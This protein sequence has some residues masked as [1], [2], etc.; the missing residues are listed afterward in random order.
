MPA[1]QHGDAADVPEHSSSSA[2]RPDVHTT[3]EPHEIAIQ[4]APSVVAEDRSR[5][6]L[7]KH[8]NFWH[9]DE[10]KMAHPEVEVITAVQLP[11]VA[12]LKCKERCLIHGHNLQTSK[13][14]QAD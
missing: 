6:K 9:E 13:S 8:I 7:L 3:A 11:V 14:C 1:P 2:A 10:L 5:G 4:Q 12:E